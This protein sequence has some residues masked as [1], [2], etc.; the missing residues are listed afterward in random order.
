[1]G[2]LSLCAMTSEPVCPRAHAVQQEKLPQ[3]EAWAPQLKSSPH[4][5]QLKEAHA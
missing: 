5:G 1:M 3:W 4:S 2:Q